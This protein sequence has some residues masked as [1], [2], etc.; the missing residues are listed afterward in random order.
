M[1]EGWSWLRGP[2]WTG[3]TLGVTLCWAVFQG[4]QPQSASLK[5]E[6][7]A[8]TLKVG[9]SRLVGWEAVLA[10]D[11]FDASRCGAV[12]QVDGASKEPWESAL[13]VR[14]LAPGECS[15]TLYAVPPDDPDSAQTRDI[16]VTVLP[17]DAPDAG[18]IP[19]QDAGPDASTALCTVP[20][21][22]LRVV[23]GRDLYMA[24]TDLD[25]GPAN[26]ACPVYTSTNEMGNV[27][28]NF[29]AGSPGY[30]IDGRGTYEILSATPATL[31]NTEGT[32]SAIALEDQV[33]NITFRRRVFA[34][35]DASVPPP[36]WAMTFL[37]RSNPDPA[38]WA[39]ELYAF[40]RQ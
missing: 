18:G 32:S 30:R 29:L 31:D 25:T 26:P 19:E 17:S 1:R 16:H 34:D 37:M 28:F 36:T 27:T 8:I 39:I 14:G 40:S 21:G 15:V 38:K 6:V 23:E 2:L 7:D 24:F 11:Q 22:K 9:E 12:A 33:I 10:Q 35:E 20:L 5:A 13:L 4:C 3:C